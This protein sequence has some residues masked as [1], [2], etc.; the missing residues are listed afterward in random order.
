MINKRMLIYV[1]LLFSGFLLWTNWQ[2]E[3]ANP[4]PAQQMSA[5][6][7]PNVPVTTTDIASSSNHAAV[8]KVPSGMKEDG[9][10]QVKTD[11][12]QIWI[13][14][15]G[16]NIVKTALLKF[17][18][19]LKD[20]RPEVIMDYDVSHLYMAQSGLIS[21]RGPD[22]PQHGQGTYHVKAKQFELPSGQN[23]L[24]VDLTWEKNGVKVIKHYDFSRGKYVI[25]S[26]YD[27][28]NHSRQAWSGRWYDQFKRIK[29]EG[30]SFFALRTYTGAAI[31]SP[32][33]KYE[34][35]TFKQMEKEDINRQIQGGWVA[36]QQRYFISA[37]VPDKNQT[38]HYYSRKGGDGTYTIG[39]MSPPW[40]IEPG[41]SETSHANQL[42]VGP[43]ES[44]RLE[45]L[46]PGSLKLTVDYGFLWMIS[47]GLFWIMKKLYNF[48]G[49]WGVVIILITL[50]IKLLFYRFSAKSYQSMARMRELQ[51][52]LQAIKDR[53]GDD[54]TQLGKATME[55][56]RK[57]KVNPMGGCLPILVQL[58]VFIALYYV[59]IEAVELR[60]APFLFWIQDLSIKDPYFILPILMGAS[61]F[62]QQKLNPT[63]PDPMQA[64]VMMFVPVALT[65]LF[66]SFPAGLVLY[67]LTNNLLSIGQQAYI[68]HSYEKNRK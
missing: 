45:A 11:L 9:L 1:G 53:C 49:N 35:I 52:R 41:K 34:K 63:P 55:L 54:K 19:S 48:F 38:F 29:P 12:M 62:L 43:E 16:G 39:Y 42:Y 44:H 4:P 33:K 46:A 24:R 58:P 14:P 3:H 68:M 22:S 6:D 37:W 57:E 18:K 47:D 31:S 17:P 7:V 64:K 23:S 56:Y 15:K 8:P 59:L 36:M 32:D 40:T 5:G 30:A 61:M 50:M 2:V 51:P 27:V 13:S 65:A 10:I 67:W 66:V 26:S 60:Q 25:V 20:K 28:I 21:D